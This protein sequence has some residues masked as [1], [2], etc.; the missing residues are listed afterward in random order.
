M[1]A[2]LPWN[3]SDMISVQVASLKSF[4]S[5]KGER[6]EGRHYYVGTEKY[7]SQEE[8]D[9][10]HDKLLGDHLYAMLLF[11]EK[12]QAIAEKISLSCDNAIDPDSCSQRLS[13]FTD[14]VIRDI[15]SSDPVLIGFTT[16]H[17]QYCA[18]IYTSKRI[19][20]QNP[21]T[22]IVLGGIALHGDPALETL[23]LFP[24]IDFIIDGEGEN[25]IWRLSQHCHARLNIWEVPQLYYRE[26]DAVL[27]SNGTELVA[28]LN[29]LP[30]PDF[31]DY[32]HA[33][34]DAG[35][36]VVPRI[37][38]EMGR[39]CRWGK[40][41]FCIEGLLSRRGYRAK[42]PER[43]INEV[44]ECVE[45]YQV[46]D[47]V[48][49]DPDVAFY[50]DMFAE[51]EKLPFDLNFMVEL[52]G[53]VRP[54]HMELM[55]RAGVRTVQIGIEAFSSRLLT[56][57]KK[58]VSLAKYVE[59]LRICRDRDVRL[60]YNNIYGAPFE[61]QQDIDEALENMRRLVFF[62]PPKLSQFRVSLGSEIIDNLDKYGIERLLPAE[63]VSGYP[64]DVASKVGMLVSFSAGY[65]FERTNRH[66]TPDRTHYLEQLQFWRQ[67]WGAS[68]TCIA[69]RGSHFIRI[70]HT[71]G[72]QR[73]HITITD[74]LE[75]QLFEFCQRLKKRKAI[76]KFF[77]EVERVSLDDALERLWKKN[78][79]FVTPEECVSLVSIEVGSTYQNVD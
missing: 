76:Y 28:D 7:F 10:I 31:S 5:S 37:T 34:K 2:A 40:C 75:R 39:G 16:T 25:P 8:I 67:V 18:S 57:F 29:D 33:V 6:V 17:M 38:I 20:L 41:S 23:S 35:V 54:S 47:F 56:E 53:L 46:L 24:W 62:Q 3:V 79:V 27:R 30:L 70:D 66:D 21:D 36:S 49:A 74:A 32:F 45:R 68:P 59:L 65:Q 52:S 42:S 19:K 22:R 73:Y 4:L 15:L 55:V 71:V 69:R 13:A 60:I 77:S 72:T 14:E 50:A 44:R 9:A 51:I 78:L 58:G 43:V 12:A 1:I 11:P 64:E 63:E 26:G 48:T 61:T